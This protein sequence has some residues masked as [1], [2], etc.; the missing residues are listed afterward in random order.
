[1]RWRSNGHW[2][3]PVIIRVPIGGYIHGG[4][5]HSQNIE[6]F[7]AHLPGIKIAYPC[8]AADAKGLLKTAIRLN[9][10]VLF[11]EHKGLYRQAYA[12]G[13][14]PDA[15]Y[16]LP[17]GKARIVQEGTDLTVI[18]WGAL[19]Q[20]SIDA[21]RDLAKQG[22]ST[23]II[24]IRTINPLDTESILESVKKTSK[25]LVA[26]EDSRFHGFGAEISAHIAEFA[27]E[28]LDA[29]VKRIGALD[30]P[31]G[32]NPVL[33]NAILPQTNWLLEAM[34]ELAAY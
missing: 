26:H 5:C 15:D 30:T 23:E 4:L 21:A 25:V 2:A 34:K 19:V 18:T 14:E 20:K 33:E 28:Y 13:P 24:D 3:C 10:P 9:D 32:F 6:A 12:S 22:V 31:I 29:P 8:S 11:L 1:M 7:F 17:F 16:L 27:F